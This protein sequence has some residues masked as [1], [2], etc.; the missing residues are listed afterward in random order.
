MVPLESLFHTLL[1]DGARS[2]TRGVE[3]EKHQHEK[4]CHKQVWWSSKT[5]KLR[6]FGRTSSTGP[7]TSGCRPFEINTFPAVVTLIADFG[8][9]CAQRVAP[10]APMFSSALYSYVLHVSLALFVLSC[11]LLLPMKVNVFFW[12]GLVPTKR[13]KSGTEVKTRVFLTLTRVFKK[14]SK[15]SFVYDVLPV[16]DVMGSTTFP[17]FLAYLRFQSPSHLFKL[18]IN[19]SPFNPQLH[20]QNIALNETQFLKGSGRFADTCRHE[21]SVEV[22]GEGTEEHAQISLCLPEASR[23]GENQ[24]HAR[25]T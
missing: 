19:K 14:F 22:A 18:S 3:A 6:P 25:D 5:L 4:H 8:L 2:F 20:V 21:I 1:I 24:G 12:F 9:V 11:S 7:H 17:L 23:S 10:I 13:L 16:C 15:S